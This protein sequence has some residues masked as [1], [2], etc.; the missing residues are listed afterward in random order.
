MSNKTTYQISRLMST[1]KNIGTYLC[2]ICSTKLRFVQSSSEE[3]R[4]EFMVH[5]IFISIQQFKQFT[6]FEAK[7]LYLFILTRLH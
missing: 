2:S 6:M 5:F 4:G 3:A 1:N 7:V